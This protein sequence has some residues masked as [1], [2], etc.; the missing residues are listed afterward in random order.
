MTFL[1]SLPLG[2]GSLYYPR[3][4]IP[5]HA[6]ISSAGHT[7]LDRDEGAL[8]YDFNG[9]K[10]GQEEFVV[11]QYT[12]AGEGRLRYEGEDY[13]LLPQTA[14]V[15]HIP[16]DH[17]YFLPESSR[18][19]EFIY[20]CLY[21]SELLRICARAESSLGPVISVDPR[22]ELARLSGV[23]V[24][25]TVAARND[26]DAHRFS[27]MAYSWA[28]AL[29]GLIPGEGRGEEPA[30]VARARQFCRSHMDKPIGVEEISRAARCS[31]SHL[32][33]LFR[34]S[35]QMGVQEYLEYI[36]MQRAVRLLTPGD[37]TV[38]E[39]ARRCGFADE[40]YFCKVFRRNFNRS[41]GQFRRFGL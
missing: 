35:W 10:R 12:L 32:T 38:K 16:H 36:R 17:R 40:N 22:G 20:L 9:L 37:L 1:Q 33:R 30:A 19:W 5:L 8:N 4:G 28:M 18:M 21:G 39:V 27:A 41:P 14:M 6:L 2:N 24:K 34:A 31:R 11:F 26:P 13:A 15:V 23:I 7:R 29:A 25:E 3:R